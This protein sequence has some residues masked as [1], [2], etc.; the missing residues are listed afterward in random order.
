MLGR[1]DDCEPRGVRRWPWGLAAALASIGGGC[2]PRKAEIAASVLIAAPS[3]LLLGFGLLAIL[4][5]LERRPPR[6]RWR[7]WPGIVGVVATVALAILAGTGP[8][9]AEG[10]RW[11]MVALYLFGSTYLTLLLALWAI[12]RLAGAASIAYAWSWL[13]PAALLLTPAV[14]VIG[15]E[16]LGDWVGDLWVYPGWFGVPPLSLFA[17]VLVVQILAN[18]DPVASALDDDD[19]L[20]VGSEA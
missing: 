20:D 4:F 16:P 19:A 14:M 11:H 6:L 17:V 15:G 9:G 2:G 7:L 5:S 18:R 3:A 13:P 1:H 8:N 10:A 12:L